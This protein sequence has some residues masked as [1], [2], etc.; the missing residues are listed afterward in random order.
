MPTSG[1]R[2]CYALPVR[3]WDSHKGDFGAVGVLGGAP[4]MAG[5]ALLAARAALA[6]GAGRVYVGLLDRRIA[7]D[8]LAPELMVRTAR[9]LPRL[10]AP[11]CLV[12]GPGLGDSGG[13]RRSLADALA[14]P[15]AL[16]LDADALNLL[17][18]DATLLAATRARAW[19]TILTPHPG[20][21]ARLLGRASVDVQA[22][23]PGAAEALVALSGAIVVLKGAGTL[24]AAP[25]TPS[26]INSTGNPGMAAPGM[27][28]ALCGIVAALIAQGMAA[29]DAAIAGVHLHGAA[30]D[31][32]VARGHGPR[33]LTASRLIEE[34]HRLLNDAAALDSG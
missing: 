4:G 26:V 17:A 16:L 11:A 5:A 19:P 6:C 9:A 21:A 24:I 3:A 20:E 2:P 15:H 28:D 22:D 7:F 18:R 1:A 10:P 13:A 25:R 29:L 14:V 27:G 30:G 12:A 34:A 33:G 31:A 23:R 32:A 8:P